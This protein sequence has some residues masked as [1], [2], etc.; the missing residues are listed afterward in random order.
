MSKLISTVVVFNFPSLFLFILLKIAGA[1]SYYAPHHSLG[2]QCG[3]ITVQKNE[4][5]RVWYT[6][7]GRYLSI[8]AI[9]QDTKLGVVMSAVMSSCQGNRSVPLAQGV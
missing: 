5:V 7:G 1:T 4:C 8:V 3:V 6:V 9:L 2:T